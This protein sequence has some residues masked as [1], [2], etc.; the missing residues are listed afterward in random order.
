MVK[1]SERDV[2]VDKTSLAMYTERIIKRRELEDIA[3]EYKV[4]TR[5]VQRKVSAVVEAVK[6]L[7]DLKAEALKASP[8]TGNMDESEDERVPDRSEKKPS[9]DKPPVIP[10]RISKGIVERESIPRGEPSGGNSVSVR[11]GR[12]YNTEITMPKTNP[13]SGIQDM[14]SISKV[15]VSAGVVAGSGLVKM[16]D[17]L[18][19]T[20]IP[21]GQRAMMM[22]QGSNV[23]SNM[24]L[25]LVEAARMFEES[26]VV[27]EQDI[28]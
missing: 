11:D 3:K 9:K 18:T 7:A 20:D 13:L 19:R 12:D 4:S 1:T 15:G 28:R 25:G 6:E 16:R 23:V 17:A 14:M 8:G 27:E 10:G 2:K 22:A 24:L 26:N 5:T 21:L